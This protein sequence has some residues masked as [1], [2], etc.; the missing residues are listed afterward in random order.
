MASTNNSTNNSNNNSGLRV[1]AKYGN[2]TLSIQSPKTGIWIKLKTDDK[3]VDSMSAKLQEIILGIESDGV[4]HHEFTTVLSRDDLRL[5]WEEFSSQGGVVQKETVKVTTFTPTPAPAPAPA[6]VAMTRRHESAIESITNRRAGLDAKS[7]DLMERSIERAQNAVR[8]LADDRYWQ[9]EYDIPETVK[10]KCPNPSG[11]LWRYAFRTSGSCWVIGQREL[12]KPIIQE[13]IERYR[14]EGCTVDLVKYDADQ[15]DNVRRKARRALDTCLQEAHRSLI[16]R[17]MSADER[18]EEARKAAQTSA[19]LTDAERTRANTVRAIIKGAAEAL[20]NACKCAE[21]Y[22]E[23]GDSANL[24]QALREA[25]RAAALAF[26]A[27][28]RPQG[29]KPAVIV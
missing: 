5:L 18:L 12:N 28:H 8:R 21:I 26:N 13:W 17:I 9:I 10:G 29:L 14:A 27:R 15:L 16:S 2:N 24:I 22:D 4:P 25:T 6:P 19:E 20:A 3:A 7:V 23:F 11:W 1:K